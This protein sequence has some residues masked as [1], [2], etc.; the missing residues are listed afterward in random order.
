[1]FR[2]LRQIKLQVDLP[3]EQSLPLNFLIFAVRGGS[4][5]Q[6]PYRHT[7]NV[8]RA[9][10]PNSKIGLQNARGTHVAG[11]RNAQVLMAFDCTVLI[12]S[13]I[14]FVLPGET[15]TLLI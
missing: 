14:Y 7:Q 12:A 2:C 1:M 6:Q 11:V 15:N 13:V 10:L 3:E 8:D 4:P 9:V 5:F